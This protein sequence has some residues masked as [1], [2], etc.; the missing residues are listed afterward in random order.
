MNEFDKRIPVVIH[1][2][3]AKLQQ[4]LSPLFDPAHT[5]AVE[6]LGDSLLTS[7]LSL[8]SAYCLLFLPS[9]LIYSTGQPP[10]GF[11]GLVY[12][13]HQM[14]GFPPAVTHCAISLRSRSL[15][16]GIQLA[17]IAWKPLP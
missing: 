8:V 4:V 3:A 16:S 6:A 10:V 9:W 15:Q 12:F 11:D 2:D 1:L 7:S 17:S 13:L 5:A 14:D